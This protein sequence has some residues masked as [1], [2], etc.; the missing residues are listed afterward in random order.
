MADLKTAMS[1]VL[2]VDG[3]TP[4]ELEKTVSS[5]ITMD[6]NEITE[7]QTRGKQWVNKH[8]D[9]DHVG[10]ILASLAEGNY[11]GDTES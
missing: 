2:I 11:D 5:V 4:A 7:R 3:E 1:D 6:E 10:Q 9:H 8:C